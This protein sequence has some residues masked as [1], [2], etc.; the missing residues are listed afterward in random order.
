MHKV[1]HGA[2]ALGQQ[3]VDGDGLH[4]EELG[5]LTAG[6]RARIFCNVQLSNTYL[7][8]RTGRTM[9]VTVLSVTEKTGYDGRANEALLQLGQQACAATRAA[10]TAPPGERFMLLEKAMDLRKRELD[11]W[12]AF[13]DKIGQ[14][15]AAMGIANVHML[16]QQLFQ[17]T[18]QL[19]QQESNSIEQARTWYARADAFL[20]GLDDEAAV[21]QRVLVRQN[22]L[23]LELLGMSRF[24]DKPVRVAGLV[25]AVHVLHAA[26]LLRVTLHHYLDPE[27]FLRSERH[28]RN[29]RGNEF[30]TLSASRLASLCA[31]MDRTTCWRNVHTIRLIRWRVGEY[32][33]YTF[34]FVSTDEHGNEVTSTLDA[35]LFNPSRIA[36][37]ESRFLERLGLRRYD[38]HLA[39]ARRR[40]LT[41]CDCMSQPS[42]TDAVEWR[43]PHT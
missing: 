29:R 13:G 36:F 41:L 19:Q 10:A 16:T 1:G 30:Q 38:V 35:I 28:E 25:N 24:V 20:E 17:Q 5:C 15:M 9:P 42:H 26:P 11:A 7:R 22:G 18:L 34:E 3:L 21:Q 43:L 27:D 4:T 37:L 8:H 40:W 31:Q 39:T 14:S 2:M 23:Q 12:T 32:V 33:E 6:E